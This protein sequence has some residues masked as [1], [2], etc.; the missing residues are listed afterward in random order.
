MSESA[1]PQIISD[2]LHGHI[3][4]RCLHVVARLG[5]ADALEEQPATAAEL[6]ART[7]AS[8]DALERMLRLL[9]SYG[10]FVPAGDGYAHTPASRLL[11]GDHPQSLRAYAQLHGMPPFWSAF[12]DLERAAKTGAPVIG[13]TTLIDY[14]AS[15]PQESRLFNESMV[16]KS[17]AASAALTQFYD[18]GSFDTIADIGGGRGHL[19]RAILDAAPRASGVLFELPHVIADASPAPRLELV[20]GDF[21]KDPLPPADLYL[22]MEVLHDWPDADAARILAAVRRA[23]PPHARLLIVESL[24]G[25]TQ[26]LGRT[27]D[28]VMLALT[29]GRERARSEYSALLAA[30]GFELARV[31]DTR[32][33]FA[34]AEAVVV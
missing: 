32:T 22:L 30:T 11:R 19:L 4:A 3:G 2:L 15:H 13:W 7:G 33:R 25:E 12:T 14:F 10:V 23:A 28:I 6:A 8:A 24:V 16:S 18:F 29:G 9:S 20:A 27:I 21:F 5:V 34:V 26:G 17:V 31:L 1:P